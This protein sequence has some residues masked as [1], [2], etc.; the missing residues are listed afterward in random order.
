MSFANAYASVLDYDGRSA[1]SVERGSIGGLANFKAQEVA[2]ANVSYV[3]PEDGPSRPTAMR[4]QP[5]DK[6]QVV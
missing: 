6:P 1:L 2:A 3:V 4:G 5:L